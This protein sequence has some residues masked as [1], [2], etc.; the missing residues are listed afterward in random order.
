VTADAAK[1]L[2]HDRELLACE[3]LAIAF[4]VVVKRRVF[5]Q[6]ASQ[7][8]LGLVICFVRFVALVLEALALS[9][10]PSLRL[11]EIKEGC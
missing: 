1:V 3:F 10:V 7:R 11:V 9:L 4:V 5:R 2:V 6:Y 8:A